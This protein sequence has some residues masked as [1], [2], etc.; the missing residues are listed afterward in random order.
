MSRPD[1]HHA[2]V[3]VIWGCNQYNKGNTVV[4]DLSLIHIW[5]CRSAFPKT[6]A[7]MRLAPLSKLRLQSYAFP[8]VKPRKRCRAGNRSQN[9]AAGVLFL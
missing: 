5:I 4:D 1:I 6:I 3:V 9:F 2:G 8:A 7:F